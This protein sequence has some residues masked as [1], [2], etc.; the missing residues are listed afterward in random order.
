MSEPNIQ[1][2]I[3]NLLI[4]KVG[5][6][7]L[8]RIVV[9]CTLLFKHNVESMQTRPCI[10]KNSEYKGKLYWIFKRCIFFEIQKRYWQQCTYV[11][12]LLRNI[13]CVTT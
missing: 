10:D 1:V 5:R 11:P 13:E 4:Q 12:L 9:Q 6:Y 3:F 2:H 8:D 7:Y